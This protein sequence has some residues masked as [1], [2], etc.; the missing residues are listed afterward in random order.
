MAAAA[1]DG[2]LRRQDWSWYDSSGKSARHFAEHYSS[3]ES[4]TCNICCAR[5][6]LPAQPFQREAPSCT[7]CGSSVRVRGL[8]HALSKELLGASLALTR[9]S[10]RA[11]PLRTGRKRRAFVFRAPP[12]EAGLPQYLLRSRATP[13]LTQPSRRRHWQ[14]RFR[15]G[16]RG[17]RARPGAG[18]TRVLFRSAIAQA[19]RR[20]GLHAFPTRSIPVP[21]NISRPSANSGSRRLAAERY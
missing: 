6:T 20:A 3:M 10:A 9:L 19:Q 4:F 13:R 16:Q 21:P 18:G 8:L 15:L 12:R 1:E 2:A 5:N 17:L 11:Q 14:V 7:N